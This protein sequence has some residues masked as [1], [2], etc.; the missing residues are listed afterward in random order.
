M[1]S[2]FGVHFFLAH[3]VVVFENRNSPLELF[4]KFQTIFGGTVVFCGRFEWYYHETDMPF[5]VKVAG[6]KQ[7]CRLNVCCISV[8]A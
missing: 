2:A 5:N 7:S 8:E 6:Q 3:P 4:V 1:C